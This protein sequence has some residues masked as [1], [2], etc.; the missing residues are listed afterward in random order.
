LDTGGGE[1]VGWVVLAEPD[2]DD[3][4]VHRSL[5]SRVN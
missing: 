3:F 5:R 1:D 4:F 2:G